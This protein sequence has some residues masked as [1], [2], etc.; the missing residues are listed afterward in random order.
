MST[1]TLPLRR[2][3]TGLVAVLLAPAAL[4][5]PGHDVHASF[6]LADGLLHLLSEPD[7]VVLLVF[8]VV[9][10]VVAARA[11]RARRSA[12]RSATTGRR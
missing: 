3:G 7:H 8:A 4:A 10:G 11:R 9:A 5:H 2:L 1:V 6:G 12:D